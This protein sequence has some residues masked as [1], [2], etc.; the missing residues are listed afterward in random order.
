M[1]RTRMLYNII[2]LS[3]CETDVDWNV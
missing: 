3:L 2:N 1:K